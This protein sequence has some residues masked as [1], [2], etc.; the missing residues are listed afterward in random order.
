MGEDWLNILEAR[1]REKSLAVFQFE[2]EEWRRL[3]ESRLGAHEFTVARSRE[4]MSEV[5]ALTACLIF[6]TDGHRAEAHFGLVSSRLAVST[7]D[8][9]VKV[10]R[11][12]PIHPSS[13]TRLLRLVR[14]QPHAGNLQRRLAS[15]ETVIV[16][17][18]KLSAHVVNKLAEI[19]ANHGPLRT[20]A[21]SL[22]SPTHFHT[23]ADVQ[24]DAV[25]TALRAFGL[26]ANDQASSL[27]LVPGKETALER[28]HILEDAVIEHDARAIPGYDLVGSDI[29]GYAVFEKDLERLEVYTANRRS[30]EHAFG[31]DLIY[32]NVTR[33]NIVMLQYKMLEPVNKRGGDKDWIYRPD[34]QLDSE[35]R[36]M[37]QFSTQHPP[38]QY[39][40]RLNP[41]VFYLKFIKRD[42][43]LK[44]AAIITPLDHFERIRADPTCQG[45]RGGLRISFNG[46]AGRYLR[47]SA[48][49]DLLRSGYIGAH[50][51]TTAH[52]KEL[53]QAVIRGNKAV[54]AAVQSQSDDADTDL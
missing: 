37:R 50:A 52:L 20:V 17:S 14:E 22:S 49:L 43:A 4:A 34:A 27:E 12:L 15:D 18:S 7:L 40:Y 29:T 53:V 6:G 42:G 23:M 2:G 38:G 36:R 54:V 11:A 3:R 26:S 25:Q 41:Q 28:V 10:R 47:Q 9:R 21:A 32:L 5:Q 19:E 24:E 39:E 31:V 33:Q 30:L 1:V 46:L 35:I 44:N 13:K 8:S 16:L 51:E 45:P 48:F